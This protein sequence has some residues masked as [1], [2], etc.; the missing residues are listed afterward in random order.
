MKCFLLRRLQMDES[1]K[2]GDSIHKILE[3]DGVVTGG[4]VLKLYEGLFDESTSYSNFLQALYYFLGRGKSVGYLSDDYDLYIDGDMVYNYYTPQQAQL[5]NSVKVD[6][7]DGY[8]KANIKTKEDDTVPLKDYHDL[9]RRV[10]TLE[11]SNKKLSKSNARYRKSNTGLYLVVSLLVVGLGVSTYYAITKQPTP[12]AVVTEEVKSYKSDSVS[13]L[14]SDS[15]RNYLKSDLTKEEVNSVKDSLPN[16]HLPED[17]K[18]NELSL[19]NEL[20]S[21]FDLY[22]K[23]VQI[24]DD[25]YQPVDY[26]ALSKEIES[27]NNS[28]I[29]ATLLNTLV[30]LLSD[31]NT[32]LSIETSLANYPTTVEEY[33]TLETSINSISS[34]SPKLKGTAL[35]DLNSVKAYMIE[36]GYELE[37]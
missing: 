22:S 5:F 32:F 30:T 34:L 24:G 3:L 12:R 36:Q 19:V 14:F 23:I 7:L 29:R 21:Y 2:I 10:S 4:L 28:T 37:E 35:E 8:Q 9:E 17:V 31:R 1:R 20:L 18:F 26:L 33:K 11:R 6:I 13:S 15:T 25:A 16:E 27:I